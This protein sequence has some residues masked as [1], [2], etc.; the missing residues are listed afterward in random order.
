MQ[1]WY[2]IKDENSHFLLFLPSTFH[3]EWR[4]QLEAALWWHVPACKSLQCRKVCEK[5]CLK[6]VWK[7]RRKEDPS[8]SAGI[9][10][11]TVQFLPVAYCWYD[12][13]H[14]YK[15]NVEN[16]SII[17]NVNYATVHQI[18]WYFFVLYWY[19]QLKF[20]LNFVGSCI[21]TSIVCSCW[22][23]EAV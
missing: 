18:I 1:D 15:N 21:W 8:C 19:T 4:Q 9:K 5:I 6:S 10:T 16:V 17:S 20:N 3:P 13:D 7:Q 2:S 14:M 12:N 22:W 23:R 11:A